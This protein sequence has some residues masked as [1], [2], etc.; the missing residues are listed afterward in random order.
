MILRFASA[1]AL[2]AALA[3]DGASAQRS[4]VRVLQVPTTHAWQ[5]AQTGL[6][7]PSS[8]AGQA[9]RS[10]RD[11]GTEELD[12]IADF[13]APDG[14]VT[15]TLYLFRS[16]VPS[17][18]LWFDRART[19]LEQMKRFPLGQ[20]LPVRRFALRQGES[21]SGLSVAYPVTGPGFASTAVAVAPL[22]GWMVKVRMSSPSLNADQLGTRLQTWLAA[23][24]WPALGT[25][26]PAPAASPITPC[27][28]ALA[29]EKAR[30]IKPDMSQAVLGSLFALAQSV[31]PAALSTSYCREPQQNVEYGVYRR[32]GSAEGYLLAFTDAGNALSVGSS[33]NFE[34]KKPRASLTMLELGYTRVLPS[35]TRLPSPEQ[36]IAAL[37]KMQPTSSVKVGTTTVSLHGPGIKK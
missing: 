36:V 11:T 37:P 23:V 16:Q 3:P 6:V 9:R 32:D 8:V 4:Q 1:I 33:V 26:A 13:A 24:R 22:N 18:P 25:A 31:K 27:P 15:T 10:V 5:H 17:A 12:V 35:F 2:C 7:L 28:T 29:Y 20:P 19:V 30:M 14:S 34:T 21:E